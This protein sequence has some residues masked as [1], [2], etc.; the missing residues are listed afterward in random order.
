MV[1]EARLVGN[2]GVRVVACRCARVPVD[3]VVIGRIR[4]GVRRI[5]E[6]G[7]VRIAIG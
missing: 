7:G 2:H 3:V 6:A 1:A 5:G 4:A